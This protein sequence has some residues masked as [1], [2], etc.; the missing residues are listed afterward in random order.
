L[1]WTCREDIVTTLNSVLAG[2]DNT[3]KTFAALLSPANDSGVF[4]AALVRLEDHT[5]RVDIQAAGLTP[6]QIHAQHIHGFEDDRPST[7]PTIALDT[8]RDGFVEEGEA[9][10]TATGPVILSLTASGDV[11]NIELSEDFPR[12][13]ET[14]RLSFHQTYSFDENDPQQ[15]AIFQELVDRLEGREVQLH[16]LDVPAG[17]GAGTPGEINGEGGYVA[18]LPVANGLLH[19][20]PAGIELIGFD[21]LA[22]LSTSAVDFLMG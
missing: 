17:E 10:P 15:A 22:G 16:G 5:V 19:E 1:K 18:P 11:N 6:D 13:D 7:L 12:V 14:G 20:L 9:G 2:T 21:Q 4:G 3:G 8:D